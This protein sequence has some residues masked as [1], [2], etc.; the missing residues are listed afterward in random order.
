[1]VLYYLRF[2]KQT[3]NSFFFMTLKKTCWCLH[4]FYTLKG[5]SIYELLKGIKV[6]N[7]LSTFVYMHVTFVSSNLI[8]AH[9]YVE[10]CKTG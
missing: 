1:M 8:Y 6:F 7:P 10:F 9:C 3:C 4:E 5:R 2:I